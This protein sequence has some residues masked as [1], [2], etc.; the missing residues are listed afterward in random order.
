MEVPV[1]SRDEQFVVGV[2]QQP[3]DGA[4][5]LGIRDVPLELDETDAMLRKQLARSGEH[6]TFVAFYVDLQAVDRSLAEYVVECHDVDFSRVAWILNGFEVLSRMVGAGEHRSPWSV[7]DPSAVDF[8]AA[9]VQGEIVAQARD[10]T[11]AWLECDD[12]GAE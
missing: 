2:S 12:F 8:G 1:S 10:E 9:L 6:P 5:V 7:R 3:S 4:S 11:V